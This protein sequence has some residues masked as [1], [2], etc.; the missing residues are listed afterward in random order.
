MG[1]GYGEHKPQAPVVEEDEIVIRRGLVIGVMAAALRQKLPEVRESVEPFYL[2]ER[3][4]PS[5]VGMVHVQIVRSAIEDLRGMARRRGGQAQAFVEATR[6]YTPWLG[7]PASEA[8]T[9]QLEAALSELYTEAGWA[10]YDSGEDGRGCF[11]RALRLADTAKDPYGV[12]NAAWHA[13]ATLVRSGHPNDALKLFQL[14]KFHLRLFP[15]RQSPSASVPA[16]DSWLPILT[17]RLSRTSATAY[18]VMK[19]PD[20][21]ERCLAEANDGWEP[22]DAFD[23]ANAD[24]AAA[25]I[26]VDLGQLEAAEQL[27]ASAVRSFAYRR[28]QIR[29]ELLLAEI[30]VRAGEPRGLELAHQAITQVSTLQSVAVR[31]ERLIPLATALEAR[32]GSDT[33]E[34][35]RTARQVAATR[36]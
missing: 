26:Q 22:R 29:A 5:R 28:G 9:A 20:Q 6:R 4:L 21:A 18:A 15:P 24:S 36:I 7:V 32:P 3:P 30:N 19:G 35:A 8:V 33:R 11:T 31:R 23:R 2:P 34:L 25:A 13:G 14:G 17:A 10:C 12:A 16:E 27:A 1:V